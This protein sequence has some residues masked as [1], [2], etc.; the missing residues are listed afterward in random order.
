M[1]KNIS[2]FN[3]NFLKSYDANNNKGYLLHEVD[4]EYL[5][6]PHNLHND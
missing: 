1:E 4:I 3:E 2:K 6:R 5:K